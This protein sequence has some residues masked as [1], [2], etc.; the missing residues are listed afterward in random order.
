MINLFD[1]TPTTLCHSAPLI[2]QLVLENTVQWMDNA[3]TDTYNGF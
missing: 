2:G 1:G 3:R